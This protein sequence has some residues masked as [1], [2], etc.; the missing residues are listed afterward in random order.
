MHIERV[1]ITSS[2]HS[3]QERLTEVNEVGKSGTER[4]YTRPLGRYGNFSTFGD[5]TCWFSEAHLKDLNA[6]DNVVVFNRHPED[7]FR[8][9]SRVFLSY[10]NTNYTLSFEYA[11]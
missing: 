3:V 4:V 1:V 8:D 2:G 5:M 7:R 6:K 11:D 10:A 9:P